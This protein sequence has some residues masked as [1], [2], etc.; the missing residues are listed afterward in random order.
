MQCLCVC[1]DF[2]VRVCVGMG[3][4][5]C[6]PFRGSIFTLQWVQS[7]TV[8]ICSSHDIGNQVR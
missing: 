8:Y 2:L 7:V 3:L 6:V 4:R 5:V 1:V